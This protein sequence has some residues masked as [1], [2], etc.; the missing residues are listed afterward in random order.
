LFIY[1]EHNKYFNINQQGY[2]ALDILYNLYIVL[3]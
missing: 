1:I 3:K 2:Y